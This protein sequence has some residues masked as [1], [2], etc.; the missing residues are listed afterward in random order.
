MT[1]SLP[2]NSDLLRIIERNFES[3]GLDYK[4]PMAWDT[5]DRASCCALVKD[6]MAMANTDGGY[7]VVGVVETDCGFSPV[8]LSNDQAKSFESTRLCQFIQNYSDLL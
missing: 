4:G 1:S 2:E 7:L 3:K 6:V 5:A 8:G